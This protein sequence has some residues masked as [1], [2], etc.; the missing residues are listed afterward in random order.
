MANNLRH[1]HGEQLLCRY[2]VDSAQVIEVGDLVWLNTD[3]VR[4]ATAY[5]WD[6]DLATTQASFA[7]VFVGV[8]QEASADTETAEIS[9]DISPMSV[10]EMACAS[11]TFECGDNVGPDQTGTGSSATMMDQTVEAATG[12]S[13]IGHV[14]KRVTSAATV[15]EVQFSSS[16]FGN[17]VNAVIG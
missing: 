13:A 4:P 11:A 17:N 15:V 10:Y 7:A 12:T 5:T 14:V 2:A 6:T 9:V 1:R 3:D 16:V 8:A